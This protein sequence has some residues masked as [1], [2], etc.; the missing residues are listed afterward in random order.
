MAGIRAFSLR[1]G[2]SSGNM[3]WYRVEDDERDICVRIDRYDDGEEYTNYTQTDAD[4]LQEIAD[5]IEKNDI[6]SWNFF[7]DIQNTMCSGDSWVLH[8]YYA[9]GEEIHA[10]GHTAYPEGFGEGKEAMEKLFR[11]F[12]GETEADLGI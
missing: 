2:T 11:R 8:V 9:D 7:Y 3:A 6:A 12:I 1:Y 5:V 4:F 10:M